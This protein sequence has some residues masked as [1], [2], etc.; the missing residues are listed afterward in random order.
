M[1]GVAGWRLTPPKKIP[2][3]KIRWKISRLDFLDQGG[4]ILIDNL[5]KGQTIGAEY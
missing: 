4:I 1:N 5:P 3:A 2:S